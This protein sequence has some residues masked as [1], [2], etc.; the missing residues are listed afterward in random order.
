MSDLHSGGQVRAL[1][2]I[3]TLGSDPRSGSDLSLGSGP[4]SG[5]DLGS[6]V[7]SVAPG[8][9]SVL[10]VRSTPGGQIRVGIR[11]VLCFVVGSMPCCRVSSAS[12]GYVKSRWDG[13]CLEPSPS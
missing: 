3:H 11:S 12:G 2:Q 7:R 1:G 10:G 6:G 4:S 5:S 9:R 8:V 13:A